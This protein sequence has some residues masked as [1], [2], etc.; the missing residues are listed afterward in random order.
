MAKTGNLILKKSKG[1]E[2]PITGYLFILPQL[3]LFTVFILYPIFEGFKMSLFRSTYAE[4]IF[5]GLD[6]YKELFQN[7]PAMRWLFNSFFVSFVITY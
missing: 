1:I 7:Q 2:N 4:E 3:I 5:V 6:N